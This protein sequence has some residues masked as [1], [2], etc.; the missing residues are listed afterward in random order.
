[1]SKQKQLKLVMQNP[2]LTRAASSVAKLTTSSGDEI[3]PDANQPS[4]ADPVTKYELESLLN[5]LRDSFKEDMA[6]LVNESTQSLKQSVSQLGQQVASFNTR[7]TQTE[8]TVGENFKHITEIEVEVKTLKTETQILH[9]R[10]EEL[11]NR[12]RR[13]NLRIINI[14]EGSEKDQDP[15]KFMA[16]LIMK[17]VG[18]DVFSNPPEIER[19]H[20]TPGFRAADTG[21]STKPR[22]FI[23][24]FLR[25]QDKET[26]RRWATQHPLEYSGSTLRVYPD[27]SAALAKR[28]GAFKEVKNKLYR[29]G[30]KF[31]LLHPARLQVWSGNKNHYFDSPEEAQVFA[32][33]NSSSRE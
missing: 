25:Y 13:S 15:I 7:L 18:P 10:V 32:D 14:P 19:A 1:M 3:L 20:R 27:I 16:N 28:R 33:R 22:V 29:N 26:L 8:V 23:V 17:L 6:T 4:A 12:S 21:G 2:P 11:E 31:R 24:K 30:I 9:D 5:K